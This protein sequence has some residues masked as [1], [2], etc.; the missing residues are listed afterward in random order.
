MMTPSSLKLLTNYAVISLVLT[1]IFALTSPALASTTPDD[2]VC[3]LTSTQNGSPVV[4]GSSIDPYQVATEV[5]LRE[6]MDCDGS[7]KHF[8]QTQDITPTGS[9]TPL[10]STTSPFIGTYDG[11]G[12]SISGVEVN[13]FNVV[14]TPGGNNQY[15]DGNALFVAVRDSVIK[16]LELEVTIDITSGTTSPAA[17][18]N[19]AAV[20]GWADNSVFENLVIDLKAGITAGATSLERIGGVVGRA[21]GNIGAF[22]TTTGTENITFN[23]VHVTMETSNEYGSNFGGLLAFATLANGGRLNISQSSVVISQTGSGVVHDLTGGFIGILSL[24]NSS[25]HFATALIEDSYVRGSMNLR[26]SNTDR[27]AGFISN[28][29]IRGGLTISNSYAA[30][31]FPNYNVQSSISPI[32]SNFFSATPT[33]VSGVVW[34]SSI[35]TAS[36]P[37]GSGLS[38]SDLKTVGTFTTLGWDIQ[39]GFDPTSTWG[40][41]PAVNDGYPFLVGN[42]SSDPTPPAPSMTSPTSFNVTEGTIEIGTLATTPSSQWTISNDASGLFSIDSQTGELTV[43]STANVGSYAITVKFTGANAGFGTQVLSITIASPQVIEGS[44]P[45]APMPLVPEIT[46]FSSREIKS[47]GGSVSLTGKRLDGVSELSLGGTKVTIV[48]NTATAITFTT[49]EMPVGVWDLRLVGS[50]GTLVF[51]QAIEVVEST[52][53]VGESTGELLGW[54]WTLKFLGNSRSLHAAQSDYL[55][56]ELDEHPTAET[57]ICWGYTTAAN[58]NAWAIAHATQRAQAACDLASAN[59]PEVKT[60]VRLR[61]GVSKSWAM[62]SALQFWR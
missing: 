30:V 37:I 10:G 6:I 34:D 31:Q 35:T 13:T 28:I 24:V 9:W 33:T 11:G 53:I 36:S 26:A 15:L 60:V 16:N 38:S 18:E 51:Q 55:A 52:A 12:N 4:P 56:G 39:E 62:R 48:S 7:G 43:S 17:V 8:R 57:I 58:P 45:A 21:A 32:V 46:E 27:V 50:N 41:H 61:Y 40:I 47:T 59:N 5:E 23:N 29:G 1:S 42:Y 14:K 49:G 22:S 44:E 25:T 20:A 2:G 19:N 3:D 54:T